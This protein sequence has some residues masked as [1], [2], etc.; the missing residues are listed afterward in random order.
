M[1]IRFLA[2]PPM[3]RHTIILCLLLV[4]LPMPAWAEGVGGVMYSRAN[5]TI[6]R[7][8]IPVPA[9][10]LPWEEEQEKLPENPILTFDI[11]VRD[12]L[13]FYRQQG[14]FSMNDV[15]E[16][17]GVFM[18]FPGPTPAPIRHQPQYAPIDI[19]L[20][21]QEGVIVQIIPNIVLAELDQDINPPTPILALLLLRG[22]TCADRFINPGDMVD[23]P[24]FKR[25]PTVRTAP[26]VIMPGRQ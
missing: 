19:V 13:A 26:L 10:P 8:N 14:L 12:A 4:A 3:I 16:N 24:I 18:I 2:T 1:C 20:I 23:Y 5:L 22:G 11:E 9:E 7:K 25:P 21:N 15:Q 17:K 6:T